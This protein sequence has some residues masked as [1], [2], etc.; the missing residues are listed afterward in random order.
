MFPLN[1]VLKTLLDGRAI[2]INSRFSNNLARFQYLDTKLWNFLDIYG[3]ILSPT[4]FLFVDDFH[5]GYARVHKVDKQWDF[6]NTDCKYLNIS[7][8]IGWVDNFHNGFAIIRSKY[9]NIYNFI[10]KNGEFLCH[11][12]WCLMVE[13]FKKGYARVQRTDGKWNFID[14]NGKLLTPLWFDEINKSLKGVI[15]C[16]K[17]RKEYFLDNKNRIHR[18]L[19]DYL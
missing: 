5:E 17:G 15:Y 13:P 18:K 2:A 11:G 8:E 6:I 3:G 19:N 9:G 14:G 16:R 12:Y 10:N 1:F 4:D 7:R